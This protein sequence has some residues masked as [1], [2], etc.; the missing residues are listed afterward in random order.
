MN[1]KMKI[2]ACIGLIFAL[3]ISAI[4]CRDKK[5]KP[6]G[7]YYHLLY[8]TMTGNDTGIGTYTAGHAPWKFIVTGDTRDSSDAINEEIVAEISAEIISQGVD[9]VMVSGDIVLG[10]SDPFLFDYQLDKWIAAMQ[11]VY[12]NGI[13]VY[14]V[15]GN[16]DASSKPVWDQHFTGQYALPLNGPAGE[17]NIT[18]AVAHKDALI[19]GLDVYITDARVNQAWLDNILAANTYPHILTM[20]HEPAFEAWH[21]DCLDD[22]PEN[23]DAFLTSLIDAGARTYFAGHDHFFNHARIDEGDGDPD[24]DLH[25][26]IVGTGGAP[27]RTWEGTYAGPNGSWTPTLVYDAAKYGY[28]LGEVDGYNMTLTW[29]ERNDTTSSYEATGDVLT[30][31]VTP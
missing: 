28:L 7:A 26:Y 29:W 27:L 10:S 25:H 2:F 21:T 11:S 15:R 3:S 31:T 4:N 8:G 16:H 6:Y 17:I 18:Y 1:P 22:Y 23:R 12:D 19:I 14:V 20:T 13:N 24:N 30:Y 9:F 5:E